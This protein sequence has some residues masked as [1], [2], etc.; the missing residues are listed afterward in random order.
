MLKTILSVTGKPGLFKLISSGKNMMIVE[1]LADK[2]RIPIYSR[3]KVVSLNDIAIY[4][5][6][7]E[8]A[9]RD[10]LITIKKKEEGK[11]ASVLP[12]AKPEEL[13]KYLGEILPAYDRD[14]VYNTDIKKLVNWYNTLIQSDI[15]FEKEEEPENNPEEQKEEVKA[16]AKEEKPKKAKPAAQ[17]KSVKASSDKKTGA[18]KTRTKK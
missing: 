7:G 15:D 11:V 14:R 10:V 3:D 4:T 12:G 16:V 13:R 8:V 18:A 1:S 2:K 5:D 17:Q 9:L 6:D